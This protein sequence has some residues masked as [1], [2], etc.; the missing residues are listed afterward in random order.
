MN[1]GAFSPAARSTSTVKHDTLGL[2]K[3]SLQTDRKNGVIQRVER[4]AV[5]GANTTVSA[6]YE[7]LFHLMASQCA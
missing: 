6:W 4:E 3:L 1:F 5:D 7:L 2:H